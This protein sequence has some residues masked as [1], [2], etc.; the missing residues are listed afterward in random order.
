MKPAI[1]RQP[2]SAFHIPF[3]ADAVRHFSSSRTPV[4]FSLLSLPV[5]RLPALSPLLPAPSSRA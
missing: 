4:P 3:S 2:R 5:S 1:N